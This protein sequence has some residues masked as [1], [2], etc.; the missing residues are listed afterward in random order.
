MITDFPTAFVV[1]DSSVV[2]Q[3]GTRGFLENP[4]LL[5]PL[6][7]GA[8]LTFL[9]LW[10]MLSLMSHRFGFDLT[11]FGAK[12]KLIDAPANVW[13]RHLLA[14]PFVIA[15]LLVFFAYIRG[16]LAYW[17]VAFAAVALGGAVRGAVLV[18]LIRKINKY[19]PSWVPG[20]NDSDEPSRSR[21]TATDGAGTRRPPARGRTKATADGTGI[22]GTV[23]RKVREWE[24]K[25]RDNSGKV[26][27]FI[28]KRVYKFR[29]KLLLT[30][31]AFVVAATVTG[32][33]AYLLSDSFVIAEYALS[34]FFTVSGLAYLVW[35]LPK[36]TEQKEDE[37]TVHPYPVVGLILLLTSASV[38]Q[39][40]DV[41]V[42][43]AGT[44]QSAVGSAVPYQGRLA[45]ALL[46]LPVFD[47]ATIIVGQIGFLFG[48]VIAAYYVRRD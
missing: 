46:T 9:W 26:L 22:L 40:P 30:A 45:E 36:I 11:L 6:L 16:K 21:A 48:V 20:V 42:P 44:I 19:L 3:F 13:C 24:R 25:A 8:A 14:T 39:Y 4:S 37:E 35:K 29:L 28:A 38:Y 15:A 7:V 23:R 43:G 5:A 1:A 27:K 31:A 17:T 41:Y 10:V 12:I 47:V 32:V 33:A 2:A 34:T 18:Q